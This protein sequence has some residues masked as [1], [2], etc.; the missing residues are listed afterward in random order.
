MGDK[1]RGACDVV[2]IKTAEVLTREDDGAGKLPEL[3]QRGGTGESGTQTWVG[4]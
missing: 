1:G 2:L 4:G 3:G